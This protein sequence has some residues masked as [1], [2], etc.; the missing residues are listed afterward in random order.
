MLTALLDF[1][2]GVGADV[3]LL[4]LVVLVAVVRLRVTFNVTNAPTG[5]T[6]TFKVT[7]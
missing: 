2:A 4:T 5:R 6:V 3:D 1:L 7:L